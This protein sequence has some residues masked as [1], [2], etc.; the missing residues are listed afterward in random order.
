MKRKVNLRLVTGDENLV[1]ADEIYVAFDTNGNITALKKRNDS[2]ELVAIV[3]T[4]VTLETNK[5]VEVAE[6]DIPED[7]VITINPTSGYDGM[8]KVTVTVTLTPDEPVAPD[9]AV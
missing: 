9:D 4:P 3:D 6:A 5:A 1:R 2:G 8:K 7:G